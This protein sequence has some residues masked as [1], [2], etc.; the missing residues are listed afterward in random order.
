MIFSFSFSLSLS[1]FGHSM[2]QLDVWISRPGFES[3]PQWWKHRILTSRLSEDSVLPFKSS[4]FIYTLLN[5]PLKSLSKLN[6]FSFNPSS[7]FF[8]SCPVKCLCVPHLCARFPAVPSFRLQ[9]PFPT[10]A[11]KFQILPAF[12]PLVKV[13]FPLDTPPAS[14]LPIAFCLLTDCFHEAH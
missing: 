4:D 14:Q 13:S 8:I 9:R 2:Q 1:V 3:N 10:P 12:Q 11:S 5:L 7:C 6:E